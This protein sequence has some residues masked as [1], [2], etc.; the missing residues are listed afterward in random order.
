VCVLF[1]L[2]GLRWYD[3]YAADEPRFSGL[4][5]AHRLGGGGTV[6]FGDGRLVVYGRGLLPVVPGERRSPSEV[7]I[8]RVPGHR[9][10]GKPVLEGDSLYLS[11]RCT[12]DVSI[13]DVSDIEKPAL[14]DH[15][16]VPGN[17]GRLV[18]HRGA[19]VIPNGYQG[20]WVERGQ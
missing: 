13:V 14:V 7:G 9:L 5:Y 10:T 12:G 19:L 20:L 2:G 18:L 6:P 17:P 1:Q 3:L 15:F 11:D 8:R 16:N 4:E